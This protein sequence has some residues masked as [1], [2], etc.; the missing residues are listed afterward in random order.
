MGILLPGLLV[1]CHTTKGGGYVEGSP[2]GHRAGGSAWCVD[3]CS[4]IPSG[5]IPP[6][7]GVH[8]R[9]FQEVHASEAEADDFVIYKHEWLNDGTRLGPFGGY[10]LHDIAKRLPH[11][12]FPVQVQADVRTELNEAR[13]KEA[14]RLLSLYGIADADQRVTIGFSQAEGLYGEEAERIY[15]EMILESA[16]GRGRYGGVGL[17]GAGIGG[18]AFGGSGGR[19]Y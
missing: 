9:G 14:V 8:V 2:D 3:N 10:H 16:T 1:G 18:S 4:S 11:V 13:R 7:A 19:R 12:P 15:Q 6:P 17:R 5:A